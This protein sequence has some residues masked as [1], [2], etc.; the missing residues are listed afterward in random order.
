MFPTAVVAMMPQGS[1]PRRKRSRGECAASSD[2]LGIAHYA[3]SPQRML[4][5]PKREGRGAQGTNSNATDVLLLG[6]VHST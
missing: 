5:L 4:S 6:V 3:L 2:A 1:D